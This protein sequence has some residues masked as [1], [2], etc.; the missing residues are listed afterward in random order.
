[1]SSKMR[2]FCREGKEAA[3]V[4]VYNQKPSRMTGAEAQS[5]RFMACIW[6]QQLSLYTLHRRKMGL[7][8]RGGVVVR[9]CGAVE[10][11]RAM[12]PLEPFRVL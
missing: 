4:L 2:L 8:E 11:A 7:G 5:S 3:M 1:M 6:I 12:D 9:A 10:G